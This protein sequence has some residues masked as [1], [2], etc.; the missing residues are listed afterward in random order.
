MEKIE[1]LLENTKLN[2]LHAHIS[3]SMHPEI[4]YSILLEKKFD[5]TLLDKLTEGLKFPLGTE[6][7][8][9]SEKAFCRFK[10]VYPYTGQKIKSSKIRFDEIMARFSFLHL[11]FVS[12]QTRKKIVQWVCRD[13]YLGGVRYL[14]LRADPFSPVR[15]GYEKDP[16]RVIQDYVEGI[17]SFK[18][19]FPDFDCSL[20]LS[21]TRS[22]YRD[23][24]RGSQKEKI[25]NLENEVEKILKRR[26]EDGTVKNTLLGVDT[27]NKEIVELKHFARVFEMMNKAGIISVPHAGE[28]FT[29][30]EDGLQSI[31]QA[32]YSLNAKRIGHA[33]AA[34]MNVENFY[35][36]MDGYGKA[37]TLQ[38]IDNIKKEQDA[39]LTAIKK[40][41]IAVEI[42]PT[43]NMMVTGMPLDQHPIKFFFD[44][45]IP[46]VIGT[47]DMGVFGTSLKEEISKIACAK[48]LSLGEVKSLL[49]NASFYSLKKLR[50]LKSNFISNS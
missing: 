42:N 7:E 36:K 4:I 2:D 18:Q 35:K 47:D 15:E 49:A 31:S 32:I 28:T 8:K 27:V 26:S 5:K 50:L 6:M 19:N 11:L 48:N 41:S 9:D 3:G 44:Y 16:F 33:L 14:E 46:V 37:Y 24:Q 34:V 30:F 40:N 21:I 22:L 38:R 43:A 29:S 45:R 20:I 12:S 17:E 13:A 10:E 25:E 39:V 1:D 23:D